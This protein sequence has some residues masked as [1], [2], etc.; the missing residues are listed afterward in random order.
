M[1]STSGAPL[2]AYALT[3][4]VMSTDMRT[5]MPGSSTTPTPEASPLTLMAPGAALESKQQT[6]GHEQHDRGPHERPPGLGSMCETR[7]GE[8]GGQD[9]GDQE[10][11]LG[12]A[13]AAGDDGGK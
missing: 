1:T 13:H 5:K 7:Q 8:E 2:S 11:Q 3:A 12:R 6:Q 9:D 10:E 4:T